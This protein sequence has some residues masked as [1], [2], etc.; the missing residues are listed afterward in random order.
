V[1][2]PAAKPDDE[3]LVARA[4]G[5]DDS[6]F[7]MLV[8]R[9][10][11]RVYRLACRLTGAEADAPDAVQE[12]FVQAH[13]NLGSFR[14]EARFSTWL[15]RIATNAA[16]MQRRARARR[17]AESLEQFLPAF[18]GDGVHAATVAEIA[19]ATQVEEQIDRVRLGERVRAAV[20]R[21]PD[22]YREAFVL[23]DLEELETGEVAALLD[24]SPAAVRQRV[25]RARL[26]LRGFL[27]DLARE[28]QA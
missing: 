1:T 21:L 18:D 2:V 13:R 10:W 15:Y 24:L 7:E 4:V 6:A 12:A 5:G 19:A 27:G 25:H 3:T 23:R 20:E 14:G 28:V 22:L 11:A 8:S 9:Y 26:M 16:L 17:P